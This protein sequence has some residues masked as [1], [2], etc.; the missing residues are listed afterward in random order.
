MVL[1]YQE[2]SVIHPSY[3]RKTSRA[4]AFTLSNTPAYLNT[5]VLPEKLGEERTTPKP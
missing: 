3:R 5:L 2:L 4:H 1:D